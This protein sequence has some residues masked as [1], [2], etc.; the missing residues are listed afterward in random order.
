MIIIWGTFVEI[1]D[2]NEKQS[3]LQ[4]LI[5]RMSPYLTAASHPSHGITANDSDVGDTVEL[6]IYRIDIHK[7]TGRFEKH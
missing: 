7:K 4:K 1:F 6:V 5:N 2:L 3:T